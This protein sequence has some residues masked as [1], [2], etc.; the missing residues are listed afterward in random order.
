MTGSQTSIKREDG[1]HSVAWA[2]PH[3]AELKFLQSVQSSLPEI[4]FSD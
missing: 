2:V 1:P 4:A 3:R